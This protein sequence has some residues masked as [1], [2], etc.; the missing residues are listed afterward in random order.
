MAT[1]EGTGSPAAAADA[2]TLATLRARLKTQLMHAGGMTEPLTVAVSPE[3]MTTL[4]DRV[5]ITLRDSTNQRFIEADIQEAIEKAV[6]QY[7]LYSPHHL[8]DDVALS[9]AGREIDI[10]AITDLVRVEKV[11]WDYDSAD[12]AYPPRWR[13]F[14]MWP[15]AILYINDPTEPQSG[16]TLRIWYTAAHLLNGLNSAETTTIPAEDIAFIIN[17]AAQFALHA[18]VAELAET[19][20][21]DSKV[22]E[23]LM[24]LAKEHG[25]NFRYGIRQQI[26]YWQRSAYA[27]DQNDLDE[28]IRW[29]LSEFNAVH[30]NT[31]DTTID[32]TSDG[33]EIDIA[34][35]VDCTQILSVWAPYDS[36]FPVHPPRFRSFLHWPNDIL[37]I[38]HG[39]EPADGETVRIIYRHP[40]ILDGLDAAT[41]TSLPLPHHTLLLTGASAHAAQER[42]QDMPGRWVQRKIAEWAALQLRQFKAGLKALSRDQG[43]QHSGP[44]P[45]THS[46]AWRRDDHIY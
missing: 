12:P 24:E 13:E 18:R 29:A 38:Q 40:F 1:G 28:A 9:A 6:E 43:S 30:Q 22:A 26:P 45:L 16:D 3:T 17:G 14:E 21:V 46:D 36:A 27:Y 42:V 39:A 5:E 7:S 15:G 37:Y 4:T 20:N 33:R 31:T 35:L 10:S 34:S 8:I 41:S 2:T 25:K 23:R 32:L 44:V 11:W 19:L